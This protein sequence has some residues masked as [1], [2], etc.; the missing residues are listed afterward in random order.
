MIEN[1]IS[2]IVIELLEGIIIKGMQIQKSKTPQIF[3]TYFIVVHLMTL[4][5]SEA[6]WRILPDDNGK[7]LERSS[8]A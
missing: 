5:V 2:Y 8:S 6:I 4:S 3:S 1:G 7:K